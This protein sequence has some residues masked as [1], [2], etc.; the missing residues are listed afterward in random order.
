MIFYYLTRFNVNIQSN[1][2]PLPPN[3]HYYQPHFR[4]N[5]DAT[6]LARLDNPTRHHPHPVQS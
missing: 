1:F 5:F 3:G 2:A 4:T 6:D